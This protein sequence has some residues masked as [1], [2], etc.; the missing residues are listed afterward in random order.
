MMT[1]EAV[2]DNLA[3]WLAEWRRPRCSPGTHSSLLAGRAV[4]MIDS[5]LTARAI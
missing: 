5:L 1:S 4:V 3:E 2:S